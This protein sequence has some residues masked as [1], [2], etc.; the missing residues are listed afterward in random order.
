MNDFWTSLIR[1]VTPM[2]AG[3]VVAVAAKAGWDLH[4]DAAVQAVGFGLALVWYIASRLLEKWKPG[5]GWLLGSPKQ[6][7][8]QPTPPSS[9]SN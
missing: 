6:P 9:M 7:S 3:F 1:T 2:V 5:F 4:S 8:Y